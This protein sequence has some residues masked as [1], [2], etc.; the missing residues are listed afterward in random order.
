V[1]DD[2]PLWFGTVGGGDDHGADPGAEDEYR[3]RK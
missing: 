2:Y 3:E 1:P